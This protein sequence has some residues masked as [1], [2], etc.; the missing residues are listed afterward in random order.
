MPDPLPFAPRRAL[1]GTGFVATALGIGDLADRNVPIETCVA[2]A[3][4]ALDAGL[5]V[6]DTAPN[7]E[8]GYSEQIVGRAVREVRRDAVFVIDKIDHHDRPVGPQ[9]DESL[10]RLQLNFTDAFVFH[11][12]SSLEV[13]NRLCQPGGGFDQIA[14]AVKS[15]KSR[16][17]GISSHNPDVLRSALEAGVCDVVMFPLG[18][19]VDSRYVTE[20][21]PL[22]RTRG[23]GTVCFKTFGAGKL[24][25][26]TTGYNQPLKSRPRGKV[27]SGG[28][29]DA[30]PILPRLTVA[31]CLHY[32][33]TLDPDVALLG[34]SYPNEQDAAFA[35]ARSFRPLT[36]DQM[37][38]IQQRAKDA[39]RD[40]GPC[41][42]NPDP[43]L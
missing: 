21:L 29:D 32:T 11:N 39:R 17:R 12:L 35:A 13:F 38:D 37:D 25:G 30:E 9:I 19:F 16:F 1:G 43:E 40:K 7:Y 6:I 24:V 41:W 28:T 22:A 8:D 5:N 2:T 10:G 31:E 3:R 18:P 23:I 4:R 27:S 36:L 42:W 20:T 14:D 26:D 34:L 15:G 33:L